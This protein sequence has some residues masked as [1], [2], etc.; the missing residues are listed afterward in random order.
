MQ[1]VKLMISV[2]LLIEVIIVSAGKQ[3]AVSLNNGLD[4]FEEGK[5]FSFPLAEVL[6]VELDELEEDAL[7]KRLRVLAAALLIEQ[8]HQAIED[9][10]GWDVIIAEVDK[11]QHS[12]SIE[13]WQGRFPN[14]KQLLM[15][16]CPLLK[17]IIA[18]LYLVLVL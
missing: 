13:H 1:A 2:S 8:R 4:D 16:R 17:S 11:F 10:P 18:L 6:A 12:P 3:L 15:Q 7:Y 9:K 5:V 14:T